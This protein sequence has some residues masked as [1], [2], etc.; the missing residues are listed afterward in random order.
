M[1]PEVN[2]SAKTPE[3]SLETPE[4]KKSAKKWLTS[5]DVQWSGR[6]ISLSMY[7]YNYTQFV[8]IH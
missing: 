1:F 4:V 2:Q 3:E 7:I 8:G 6:C 5:G